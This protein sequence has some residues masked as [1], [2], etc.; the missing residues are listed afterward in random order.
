[1][2]ILSKYAQLLVH[3]CL[4][5]KA[6]EKL[7]I[8]STC[9][10]ASLVK[11]VYK[12]ALK[13]GCHVHFNL[14]FEGQ[15][16]I[17]F[18]EANNEQLSYVDPFYETIIKTFDAYLV[19]RAPFS[20]EDEFGHFTEKTRI[21]QNVLKDIHFIYNER[22]ANRSLKRTLCQFPTEISAANAGMTLDEYENFVFKACHLYDEDPAESW[23][24]LGLEQQKW[25]DFL[26]Q[27]NQIQY[28]NKN[29][30]ITFNVKDRIWINSNGKTNMPSGEV[31]TS[32]IEDSV[33]GFVY[34]DLPSMYLGKEIE[35]VKLVVEAGK[36]VSWTAKKGQALL[37]EIFKIEGSRHFGEVAIGT[38]YR[39][40]KSTKNILFDEKIGGTIHM[41]LGQSYKQTGGKNE[42]SIHWDLI[43]SMNDGGQIYA[44]GQLIYEKGR[45]IL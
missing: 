32:P 9:L 39:I 33:N 24:Q 37:D 1:M 6:G 36:V 35:G 11:E 3:Y 12:E 31:Y 27:C 10:A 40:Q 22:T 23:N 16:K 43:A 4:E 38:N 2:N 21:R 42:S 19:I 44:D 28:K 20:N 29:T 7:Y 13:I 45:F 15:N 8:Q 18:A 5:L 41:A 25:V 30:D 17:F 34:F 14:S 26:N